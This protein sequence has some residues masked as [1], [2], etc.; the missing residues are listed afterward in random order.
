MSP[1]I[2]LVIFDFDGTL[3]D[4]HESI[5]HTL[6][7]TFTHLLPPSVESPSETAIAAAI[8]IGLCLTTTILQVYP[9]DPDAPSLDA[10]FMEKFFLAYRSLYRTYGKPL[11]KPFPHVRELLTQLRAWKIPCAIVSN[12]GT[13]AV[14]DILAAH[15]VLY[16]IELVVNDGEPVDCSRKPDPESWIKAVKP[17]F[18]QDTVMRTGLG[19]L[20]GEN[21]LVVGDTET[22][23]KYA[24]NIGAKSVWCSYGYGMTKRCMNLKPDFVVKG[25]DEVM[26]LLQHDRE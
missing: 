23:I 8:S 1:S 15:D 17:V 3:F 21:V 24:Q 5:T 11:I 13:A 7:I 6:A 22:D 18:E 14:H 2:K 12:K 20:R 10:E 9:D 25:L 26:A 16:L 4:T 19:E